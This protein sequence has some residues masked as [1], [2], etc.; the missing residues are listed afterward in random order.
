MAICIAYEQLRETHAILK[1]LGRSYTV[2]DMCGNTHY[3]ARPE[4]VRFETA[5]KEYR[6]LLVEIRFSPCRSMTKRTNCEISIGAS[7]SPG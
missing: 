2:E 5:Q 1:A 3:Q 7:S 4:C 6:S